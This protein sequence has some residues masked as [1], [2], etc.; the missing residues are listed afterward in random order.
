MKG[1]DLSQ[2]MMALRE[3]GGYF[4]WRD[5][6]GEAYVILSK[7]E[8][9][10]LQEAGEPEVQLS[11]PNAPKTET[12]ARADHVLERINREIAVYQLRQQE[13]EMAEIPIEEVE[14]EKP[15]A[16]VRFEPLKGDL[17]PEL[18]E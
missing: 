3:L 10:Q 12:E 14:Q 5:E 9:D 4:V 16:R 1:K 18:Q 17:P 8:F 11:L 7:Q 6:V 13:D 2:V 15:G